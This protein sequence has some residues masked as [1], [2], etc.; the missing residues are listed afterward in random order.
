MKHL[1]YDVAIAGCGIAGLYAALHLP[2]DRKILM[3]SKGDLSTCDSML[4]QGGICVLRDEDDYDSYF[5]DTMR[6]GHYEN[7]RESVDIMIRGSRAVIDH[8]LRLGVRF[9]KNPDGSLLYTK[10][11]AHSRPRICFHED[12][13]GQEIT[14]VL[15]RTVQALLSPVDSIAVVLGA[16][17]YD[18]SKMDAPDQSKPDQRVDWRYVIHTDKFKPARTDDNGNRENETWEGDVVTVA[19]GDT[20]TFSSREELAALI[21]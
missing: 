21:A 2:P 13:T 8:L 1:Y 18:F 14:T 15:L 19:T 17:E 12:V 3:L 16:L 10:E 11:G 9:A 7:R 6:A 20:R 4:A 5:E